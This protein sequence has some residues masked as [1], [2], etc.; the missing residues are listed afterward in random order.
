MIRFPSLRKV[1]GVVE[2]PSLLTSVDIRYMKQLLLFVSPSYT[3]IVSYQSGDSEPPGHVEVLT[4]Y[5]WVIAALISWHRACET[6][7]IWNTCCV[8]SWKPFLSLQTSGPG[9][10]AQPPDTN[11]T[12]IMKNKA[13]N[14]Y[15]QWTL[16]RSF[17]LS[18][19]ASFSH[20]ITN[21]T[22]IKIRLIV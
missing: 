12:S 4:F 8:H 16:S 17:S 11:R 9:G 13:H 7:E 14:P 1:A 2:L 10:L 15:L 3:Y 22:F 6:Y 19:W 5:F 21:D 18:L 20:W